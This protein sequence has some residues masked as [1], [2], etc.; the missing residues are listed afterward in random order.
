MR[1]IEYYSVRAMFVLA[2]VTALVASP[3]YADSKTE[4]E[5]RAREALQQLYKSAP[6]ARVLG[7]QAKG[8]LVFPSIAKG[9][10]IVGGQY[11][12]GTLF[13]NNKPAGFYNT[14]AASFGLQA[15]VQKFGYALFFMNQSD[16]KY[17]NK[18]DGWE[19]GV[20]PNITVVDEGLAT[21]FTTTT[22]REG[23]YAFFF[24]Q[25]GLMAGLGLQGSKITKMDE[26]KA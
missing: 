8:I 11:G 12:E 2:L 26:P 21:S 1:K 16:L 18:S 22:A 20:G 3:A 15:G 25:R 19:L 6:S 23:V 10:F 24:E 9:G 4:M 7:E 14:A 5:S 17:L 13:L